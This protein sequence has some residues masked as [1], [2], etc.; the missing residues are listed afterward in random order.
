MAIYIAILV[1]NRYSTQH[2]PWVNVLRVCLYMYLRTST[3]SYTLISNHLDFTTS[4]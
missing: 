1:S 4:R 2:H 3:Y